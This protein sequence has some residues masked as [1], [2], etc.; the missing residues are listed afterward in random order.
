MKSDIINLVEK[1]IRCVHTQ[2]Y[3]D[4]DRVFAKEHECTLI[5]TTNAFKGRDEIFNKFFKLLNDAYT[6]IN[7]INDGIDVNIVSDELAVAV[8][9]YH[10]EC[11]RREN[12]EPFGIRGLE[13]QIIIKEN[14]EWRLLHVHYSK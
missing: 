6:T 1:Y 4:F 13:T 5:S 10:T 14:G 12:G 9:R 2:S 7:L 8:Y 3:E 11:I